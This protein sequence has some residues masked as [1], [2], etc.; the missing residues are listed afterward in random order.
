MSMLTVMLVSAAGLTLTPVS[1]ANETH[2]EESQVVNY[3][4]E[5]LLT[6]E[7]VQQ[8]RRQIASSARSVCQENGHFTARFN[9]DTR[10]CID[11]AYRAGVEQLEIKVAEARQVSRTY[12]QAVVN[13]SEAAY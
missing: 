6:D 3:A 13:A 2:I 5:L 1:D 9:Q 10:R 4:S 7:G 11:D 8:V 12:A